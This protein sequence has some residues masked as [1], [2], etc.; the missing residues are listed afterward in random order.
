MPKLKR[1][2]ATKIGFI[3]LFCYVKISLE[4]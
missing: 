1:K 2:N 4:K 3:E